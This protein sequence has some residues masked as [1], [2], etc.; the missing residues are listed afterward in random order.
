[1]DDIN[2]DEFEDFDSESGNES[3]TDSSDCGLSDD[4]SSG[5]DDT[6]E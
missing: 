3:D 5:K 6:Y 1:M 2:L 4:S